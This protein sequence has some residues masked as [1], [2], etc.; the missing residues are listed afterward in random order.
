MNPV[1]E[2]P[3]HQAGELGADQQPRAVAAEIPNVSGS[4][5][6]A[7]RRRQLPGRRTGRT[8]LIRVDGAGSTHAFLDWLTGQRLSYSVRFGL[9]DSTPDLLLR[10]PMSL[11]LLK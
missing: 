10:L 1:E 4:W 5:A 9:P 2:D 11:V 8:V 7:A 6:A 3:H